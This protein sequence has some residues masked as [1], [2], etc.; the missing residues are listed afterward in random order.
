[1]RAVCCFD[2]HNYGVFDDEI[3]SMPTDEN[4]SISH[5]ECPLGDVCDVLRIHLEPKR[6]LIRILRQA[7]TKLLVHTYGTPQDAVGEIVEWEEIQD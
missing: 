5:S 3:W 2:L 1:M 4:T 7:G 6:G